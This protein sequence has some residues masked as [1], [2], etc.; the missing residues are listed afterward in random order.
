MKEQRV[1]TLNAKEV[2]NIMKRGGLVGKDENLLAFSV[3]GYADALQT[4]ELRIVKKRTPKPTEVRTDA[5]NNRNPAD[6]AA[7]TD[8]P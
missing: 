2:F 3:H 1:V 8:N 5:T 6:S 4:L 7:H